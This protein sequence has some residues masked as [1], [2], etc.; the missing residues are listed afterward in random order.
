M[1]LSQELNFSAEMMV[2][3]HQVEEGQKKNVRILES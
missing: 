2:G 3:Q 1:D